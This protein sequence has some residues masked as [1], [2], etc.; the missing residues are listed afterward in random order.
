[1]ENME[2]VAAELVKV[3]KTLALDVD[4]YMEWAK[5]DLEPMS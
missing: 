3:A 2:D 4:K 1:M 5:E